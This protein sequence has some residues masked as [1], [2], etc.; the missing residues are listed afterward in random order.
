MQAAGRAVGLSPWRIRTWERRYGVP[1]PTR[2]ARGR[3]LYSERDVEVLRRM[4]AL[5]ARGIPARQAAEAVR[6]DA[7]LVPLPAH[8]AAL[9]PRAAAIADAA[10]AFDEDACDAAILAAV[11]ELGWTAAL[12]GVVMPGLRLIGE[13]W[14]RGE[15]TVAQEH[16]LA[17]LVY[18][19]LCAALSALPPPAAGAPRLLLACPADEYHELG[20]AALWLLLRERGARVFYLGADVPPDVLVHAVQTLEPSVVCLSAVAPNSAPMLT[21]AARRLLEARVG[22]K[23]LVG[24]PALVAASGEPVP[25][26]RLPYLLAD[27]VDALLEA[28][29]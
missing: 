25:A 20:A 3:R 6:G 12:D 29:S 17:H 18:R 13:L 10:R 14:D 22:S 8:E 19:Q 16:F 7:D 5:V 21:E 26:A 28:A 24:G 1:R 23:V 15:A 4:A 9:D 2:S 27:A 11:E